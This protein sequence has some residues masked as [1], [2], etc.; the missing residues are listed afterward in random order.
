MS[1]QAFLQRCGRLLDRIED[2]L[3]QTGVDHDADRQG[4]VLTI[5]FENDSQM[6][7]NGQAVMQEIWLAWRGGAHHFRAEGE[8]W[9][10]T[11]SGES[12][13]AVL[14]KSVSAQSGQAVV[15]A[16]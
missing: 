2:L 15:L 8:Q 10:D 1:E 5:T 11:R 12:L 13:S 7:I 3:D 14:S 16:L 4:H 9:I 6:V